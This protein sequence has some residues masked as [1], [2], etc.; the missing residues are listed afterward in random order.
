M[1]N[2]VGVFYELDLKSRP[3]KFH[4]Q[5]LSHMTHITSREGVPK[6]EKKQILGNSYQSLLQMGNSKGKIYNLLIL[7]GSQ[8]KWK[9]KYSYIIQLTPCE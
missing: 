8:R 7:T 4:W 9:L 1:E 3:Q 5:V 2:H 6:K